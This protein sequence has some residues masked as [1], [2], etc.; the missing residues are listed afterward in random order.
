M[1][2]DHESKRFPSEKRI[3]FVVRKR[4]GWRGNEFLVLGFSC[5]LKIRT[6]QNRVRIQIQ[7]EIQIRK[8]IRIWIVEEWGKGNNTFTNTH[9]HTHM[10]TNPQKSSEQRLPNGWETGLNLTDF[11]RFPY[12]LLGTNT[13]TNAH[14]TIQHLS[15]P[16]ALFP[17]VNHTYFVL[18]SVV[19][20]TEK[21]K[22]W[23]KKVWWTR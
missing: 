19:W 14:P 23:I 16:S 5:H 2:L 1:A 6:V 22:G 21:S 13:H 7:I 11:G 18:L 20:N 8:Q 10:N 15:R 12:S 4:F 17:I 3:A 9:T